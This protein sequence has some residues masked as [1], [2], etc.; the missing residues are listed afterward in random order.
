[1]H[2][3]PRAVPPFFIR[4]VT[5]T[6]FIVVDSTGINWGTDTPGAVLFRTE[7]SAVDWCKEFDLRVDIK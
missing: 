1:M 2:P 4:Y 5:P 7:Q 6:V 3:H